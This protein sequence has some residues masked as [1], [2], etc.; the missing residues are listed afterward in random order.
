MINAKVLIAHKR[1]FKNPL[2]AALKGEGDED[3]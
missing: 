3:F 2:I 1:G